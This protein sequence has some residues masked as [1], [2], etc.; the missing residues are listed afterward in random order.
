MS[1]GD[2]IYVR[3]GNVRVN[4]SNGV[5]ILLESVMVPVPIQGTLDRLLMSLLTTTFPR[6][7][8]E[9]FALTH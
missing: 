7:S 6:M 8:T 9:S 2:S 5:S 4:V 1:Q 3:S